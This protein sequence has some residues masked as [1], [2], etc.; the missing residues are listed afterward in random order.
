MH[1]VA[2]FNY[3]H[4]IIALRMGPF[5]ASL[6][7]SH[8]YGGWT[9]QKVSGHGAHQTESK[10]AVVTT[11]VAHMSMVHIRAHARMH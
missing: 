8:P 2:D 4:N 1:F 7:P 5:V 3:Y 6:A 9:S 11:A 10:S